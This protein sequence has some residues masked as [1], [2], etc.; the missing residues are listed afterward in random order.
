MALVPE[1]WPSLK[2]CGS[3]GQQGAD[4]LRGGF[5]CLWRKIALELGDR[6]AQAKAGGGIV[7]G[8]CFHDRGKIGQGENR[9]FRLELSEESD[10]FF[11]GLCA[12]P[13]NRGNFAVGPGLVIVNRRGL[14]LH[15]QALA[16]APRSMGRLQ[17]SHKLPSVPSKLQV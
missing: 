1:F 10:R 4:L 14:Q 2:R 16:I 6:H 11:Q 8:G 12:K 9:R 17:R 7:A 15:N 3:G 5:S 13:G